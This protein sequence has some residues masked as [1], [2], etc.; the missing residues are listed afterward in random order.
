MVS[1]II[2]TGIY[3][4]MLCILFLKLPFIKSLFLS[5]KSFMTAF[6]GLFIFAGIFNC[7]NAHTSRINIFAHLYKNKMFIVVISF[8]LVVQII[9]M[10]YGGNMFRTVPL[11]LKEFVIMIT[12]SL[13]VIPIDILRKIIS[14]KYGKTGSV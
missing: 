14:K 11:S 13:T 4:T 8:I 3:T 2:I 10:Y 5:N 12:I 1:E 6:F 7:F 9:L